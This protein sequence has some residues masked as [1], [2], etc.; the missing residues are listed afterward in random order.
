MD[1]SNMTSPPATVRRTDEPPSAGPPWTWINPEGGDAGNNAERY[2]YD[3]STDSWELTY[4]TGPDTPLNPAE[5]AQWRDTGEGQQKV[6]TDGTDSGWQSIG[7]SDHSQLSGVQP[8]QHLTIGG[9]LTE[10]DG[11]LDFTDHSKPSG[12]QNTSKD[13]K[14]WSSL[15]TGNTKMGDYGTK[16]QYPNVWTTGLSGTLTNANSNYDRNGTVYLKDRFGNNIDSWSWSLSGGGS[17]SIGGSWALAYAYEWTRSGD[18][19]TLDLDIDVQELPSHSHN[20]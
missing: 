1:S 10:T 9:G 2:N 6:N 20:I 18:D 16:R 3:E 15:Y 17:T 12:T 19:C 4:A 13:A 8:Q 5:G 11:T 7:V 14:T